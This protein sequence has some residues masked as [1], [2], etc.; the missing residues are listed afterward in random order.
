MRYASLARLFTGA[1]EACFLTLVKENQSPLGLDQ[2]QMACTFE[3]E[4][5]EKY[6]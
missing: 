2:N 4:V 5:R 3:A 6:L 1:K